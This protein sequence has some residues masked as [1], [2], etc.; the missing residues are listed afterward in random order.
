MEQNQGLK[1]EEREIK[2]RNE[3]EKIKRKRKKIEKINDQG[4]R[5]KNAYSDI[6]F[7]YDT[8]LRK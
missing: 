8:K 1:E 7:E 2:E 5:V 6:I 4:K 3:K